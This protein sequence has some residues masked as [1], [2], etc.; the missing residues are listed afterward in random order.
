MQ[1]VNHRSVSM[2]VSYTEEYRTNEISNN[3]TT[4]HSTSPKLT[5]QDTHNKSCRRIVN[6]FY[7]CI[8]Q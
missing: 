7:L 1:A 2:I 5:D 6:K 8:L 3:K 4:E